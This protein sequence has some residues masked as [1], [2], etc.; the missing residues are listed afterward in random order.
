MIY[1]KTQGPTS[2]QTQL[3]LIP[4]A[5]A[6]LLTCLIS[7]NLHL[8]KKISLYFVQ[9]KLQ[10]TVEYSNIQHIHDFLKTMDSWIANHGK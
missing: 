10:D 1:T 6:T 8:A 9:N 4:P 3:S 2:E 5:E 7:Q